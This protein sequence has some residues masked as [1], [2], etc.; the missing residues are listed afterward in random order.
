[1]RNQ[2]SLHRTFFA[3]GLLIAGIVTLSCWSPPPAV[4]ATQTREQ[5]DR[6]CQGMGYDEY[7]AEQCKLRCFRNP[8]HCREMKGTQPEAPS[9]AGMAPPAESKPA[10]PIEP[11][12]VPRPERPSPPVDAR[13]MPRVERPA[14][15]AQEAPAPRSAFRWPPS[16]S[17]VPGREADAAAQILALNGIPPQHPNFQNALRTT[18]ALLVDFARNNP[19]GGSLPTAGLERI[20]KQFR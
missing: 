10:P 9:A 4:A 3:A 11:R 12:P 5:C 6:C 18:E 14:P 8:D 19:T 1:M 15:P 16:L 17:L 7:Y 13:P 2:R 20:I